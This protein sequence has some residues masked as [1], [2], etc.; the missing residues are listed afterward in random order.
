[1]LE[2]L[3][4]ELR[5]T[6]SE[7]D[8]EAVSL[9]VLGVVEQVRDQSARGSGSCGEPGRLSTEFSDEREDLLA[10][11]PD[12][13]RAGKAALRGWNRAEPGADGIRRLRRELGEVAMV[14]ASHEGPNS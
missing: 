6:L 13:M 5:A 4:Q 2:E 1:V 12:A 14:I 3:E 10:V 8:D 7:F 11:A 9:A